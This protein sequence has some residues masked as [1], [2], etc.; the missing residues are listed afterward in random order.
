MRS[1]KVAA[2]LLVSILSVIGLSWCQVA[3]TSVKGTVYDA[4]GGV[5]PRATVSLENHSTGFSRPAKTD[6]QGVYEFVQIPPGVYIITSTASGFGT[7]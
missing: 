7:T 5:V 6:G 2:L 4:Q 3:T 1:A